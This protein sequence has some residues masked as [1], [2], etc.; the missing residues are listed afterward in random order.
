MNKIILYVYCMSKMNLTSS[1]YNWFTSDKLT[2]TIKQLSENQILNIA[3]E[4]NGLFSET[5]LIEYK[6]ELTL[7]RLVVVGTQSSGK[8]SVLNG[9]I[10]MPILPMGKNMT[11]RTP[12]EIRLHHI[13]S[14]IQEGYV[15]FGDYTQEGWITEKKINI[16]LPVPLD[17]EI[18]EI[19]D[20][21]SQKTNEIAGTGM[22]INQKPIIINIFSSTVPNLSLVDLP[23]LTVVACTDKGQPADIKER[24]EDLVKSYISNKKTIILTVMQARNDLETDIGLG[25]IKKISNQ[26]I[27]GVITKPDLMNPETHVGEYLTN[28]ISKDLMVTYGYY[29]VKNRSSQELKDSN[30]LKGLELEKE[31]F[32]NH[33]EYRKPIYKDR[34][35][36]YNLTNNLSKILVASITELLPSVMTEIIALENKLNQKLDGL[37]QEIPITKEGKMAFMNKYISSFYY[38]F[39]DS[40]E[41]RGTDMNT[42]K[43]IKDTFVNYRNY[44]LEIKPFNDKKIY[45]DEYF[46]NIISSFEGNHMSFHIPPIQILEACMTDIRYKPIMTL[47]ES[48]LGCVDNICDLL[49]KLIKEISL[50]EEFALYPQLSSYLL[51]ILIDEII[52]KAKNKTKDLV[53]ELL[54]NENDYIWTENKEFI[55]VLSQI[56]KNDKHDVNAI[57]NFLETYFFSI[58]QIITHSV[59]KIIMSNTVREIEKSMLS[60][61]LQTTVT[62]DKIH[63]LKQDEEIEKTRNYY[64]DLRNRVH[65]IKK[66]FMK[67]N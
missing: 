51:T 66:N 31:Y 7:P 12:L 6:P 67:T 32:T 10:S 55:H 57:T 59:P 33:N 61:L 14:L 19:R 39:T 25:L 42:G 54:R 45:N 34:T 21:I 8:S 56:T 16:K 46:K 17:C 2:T 52:S 35:G 50:L 65:V 48:S 40:I 41:S 1:I 18:N 9:I 43:L 26:K 11:T 13:K 20:F 36:T 47:K 53:N 29:V 49:I 58:K 38:H 44:L 4:I 3:N 64:I 60:F 15:E 28:N 62:E 63:L 27:I 23:G 30:I 37:G 24:I 22:N 5:N